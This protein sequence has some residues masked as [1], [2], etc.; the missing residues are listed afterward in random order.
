VTPRTNPHSPR[1]QTARAD[2]RNSLGSNRLRAV[3]PRSAVVASVAALVALLIQHWLEPFTAGF[4]MGLLTNGGDL[5]IY[6]HGGLQVIHG[7]PLYAGEIPPGG[8]FTYPP[9]AA[10]AFIPLSL[11]NFASAKAIWMLVS[12]LALIATIWRC[13]T[14]LGYRP[15]R[16]LGVFSVAMAVVAL[17]IEAVRGTLWQGQV[18]LV[19]MA[20]IVWDLTRPGGARFRGWSVGIA[21]GIK[22][23]AVVFVP[24]LLITRQWRAAI[25]STAT[26]AATVVLTWCLLSNDSTQYWTH[27]VFQ[28]DRIGPLTHP[29]NYSIGGILATLW[30][31][32][33]MPTIWWLVGV[34][35]AGAV[36][37]YASYRAELRG[38]RLL[39]VTII[40]L[41]AC[42][43][44]PL[45]WGHHWVWTVPLLALT[46]DRAVRS[47]GAARWAWVASSTAIYLVAFMWFNAW[48]YRTALQMNGQYPTYVDALDA[49]IERMTQFD[50]LLA[51]GTHP[52][53]FVAVAV[54]AI[55]LTWRGGGTQ[56]LHRLPE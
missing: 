34:G 41:L 7:E 12:F 33:P 45:A 24:Y 39:A 16:L 6:R 26:A 27:A 4:H 37:L 52:L 15:D 5:D 50:K 2:D 32:A 3:S 36:G 10:I 18:N 22:L 1:P 38:H 17:D 13:A 9:F 25:T 40:G 30:A 53:L 35:V 47:T 29:G 43:V 44:P 21:A 46:I 23:T 54:V 49:A 14:V 42:S 8:W 19:L 55:G 51:V 56:R 28:T 11:L 48:L 20:I 31:P